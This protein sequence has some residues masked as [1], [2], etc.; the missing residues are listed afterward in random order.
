MQI[1]ILTQHYLGPKKSLAVI[2]VA[3]ESILIGITDSSIN[4][5]KTLSLM[6]DEIPDHVPGAFNETLD[7]K[8][9]ADAKNDSR[10]FN[11]SNME[12]ADE[13]FTVAGLQDLVKEKLK[14]MRS[15]T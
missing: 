15:L 5:I 1:K 3:G 7:R 11:I 10:Q 9:K 4:A 6:D 2:R 13:E 12:T 14:G 8:T